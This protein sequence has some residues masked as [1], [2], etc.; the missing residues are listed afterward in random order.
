MPKMKRRHY[1]LLPCILRAL[2]LSPTICSCDA[3]VMTAVSP[4]LVCS[5]SRRPQRRP[6]ASG[7][8][9]VLVQLISLRMTLRRLRETL[10][11]EVFCSTETSATTSCFALLYHSGFSGRSPSPRLALVGLVL[12][13]LTLLKTAA[14]AVC[15]SCYQNSSLM[16]S[17]EPV[18][19]CKRKMQVPSR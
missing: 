17:T 14:L 8:L 5:F 9:M 15:S 7:G 18:T 10:M 12:T 2:A 16:K 13:A 1:L 19:T 11:S 3:A 4:F 6:R